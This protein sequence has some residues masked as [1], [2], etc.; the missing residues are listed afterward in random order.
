[1]E[2]VDLEVTFQRF[3]PGLVAGTEPLPPPTPNHVVGGH[4][5]LPWMAAGGGK[6]YYARGGEN[7]SNAPLY[8]SYQFRL[9]VN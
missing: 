8:N 5:L 4:N 9:M 6:Y 3:D 1:M 7:V 2:L